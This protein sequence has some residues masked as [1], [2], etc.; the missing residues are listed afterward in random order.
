MGNNEV[1]KG[2]GEHKG[3]RFS[4]SKIRVKNSLENQWRLRL[5]HQTLSYT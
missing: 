4:L 3:K 5:C 1:N 2:R